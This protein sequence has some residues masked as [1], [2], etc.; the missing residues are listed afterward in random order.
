MYVRAFAFDIARGDEREV[1]TGHGV[2]FLE[3]EEC[4]VTVVVLEDKREVPDA[5]G[6]GACTVGGNENRMRRSRVDEVR[7]YRMN[8]LGR[9]SVEYESS[10][11]RRCCNAAYLV[12]RWELNIVFGS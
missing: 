9:A 6:R 10:S 4:F 8:V 5:L 11:V 7:D 3:E 12:V 1:E 2:G